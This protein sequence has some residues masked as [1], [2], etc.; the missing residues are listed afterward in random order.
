MLDII[1]IESGM[2]QRKELKSVE[3]KFFNNSVL[4][5]VSH[6]KGL[7]KRIFDKITTQQKMNNLFQVNENSM[8]QYFTANIVLG[9]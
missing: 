2:N 3:L 1:N 6:V 4:Q 7:L 5:G 8:E 9:C